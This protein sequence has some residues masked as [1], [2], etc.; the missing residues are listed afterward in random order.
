[1]IKEL[2]PLDEARL[3]EELRKRISD[4]MLS[5]IILEEDL[6]ADLVPV[7]VNPAVLEKIRRLL[8]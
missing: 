4:G 3:K 2:A 7:Y 8:R 1:M 5:T 6:P